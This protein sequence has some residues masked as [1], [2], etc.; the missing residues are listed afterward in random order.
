MN[1]QFLAHWD[2]GGSHVLSWLTVNRLP[3]I[4][5]RFLWD[6]FLQVKLLVEKE[7]IL[8]MLIGPTSRNG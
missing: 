7:F 8:K 2:F 5:F 3:I 1:K 6:K 4:F